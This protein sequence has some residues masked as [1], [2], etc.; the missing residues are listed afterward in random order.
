MTKLQ[1]VAGFPEALPIE[2]STI[3]VNWDD[4]KTG[5]GNTILWT[6]GLACCLAITL[7][8]PSQRKGN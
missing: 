7:Y 6:P 3:S 8:S 5:K 2:A 1:I 4:Y